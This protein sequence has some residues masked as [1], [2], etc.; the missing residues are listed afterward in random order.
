MKRILLLMVMAIIA[1]C[2]TASKEAL[3]PKP[4]VK[5]V[6]IIPAF[7]P[8]SFPLEISDF[9]GS[10]TRLLLGNFAKVETQKKK[11]REVQFDSAMQ[12]I[13]S[14]LDRVF[15]AA[16]MQELSKL[17]YQVSILETFER[18]PQW[19]DSINYKK[20][21]FQ[22]DAVLHLMFSSVGV[23]AP[24]NGAPFFPKLN[25][26]GVVYVKGR[27]QYLYDDGAYFGVDADKKDTDLS[28]LKDPNNIYTDFDDVMKNLER[29]HDSYRLAIPLLAKRMAN[30]IHTKLK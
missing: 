20:L 17:G 15:T 3:L 1:G 19:P 10:L 8:Q 6:E 4:I 9:S 30:D 24:K 26:A 11:D 2:S 28:A 7:R 16:M 29:L 22:G 14:G 12:S 5:T 21:S 25:T 23:H 27:N 13:S 18:D